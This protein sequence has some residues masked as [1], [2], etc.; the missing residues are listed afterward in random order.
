MVFS[1]AGEVASKTTRTVRNRNDFGAAAAIAAGMLFDKENVDNVACHVV[2]DGRVHADFF[3]YA[4][5][6]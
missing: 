6:A 1:M 3:F 2:Q 5:K 4:E